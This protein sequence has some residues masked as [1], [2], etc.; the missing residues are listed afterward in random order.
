MGAGV[1]RAL[2]I[3]QNYSPRYSFISYIATTTQSLASWPY[4]YIIIRTPFLAPNSQTKRCLNYSFVFDI[5][6]LFVYVIRLTYTILWT[7]SFGYFLFTYTAFVPARTGYNYTIRRYAVCLWVL[8]FF[9]IYIS[10][11]P[12]FQRRTI[13]PYL[14]NTVYY[15]PCL[16]YWLLL[17]L[18]FY[19]FN[20]MITI[21]SS[22]TNIS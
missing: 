5:D 18:T 16:Q 8:F 9:A 10:F 15:S 21:R 6:N 7:Y 13:Q 20:S 19:L 17:Q 11:L 14:F 1:I 22:C 2:T 12:F 4:C 3:H